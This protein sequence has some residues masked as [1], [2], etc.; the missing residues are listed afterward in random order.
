MTELT[1]APHGQSGAPKPTF[2]Q[3][4]AAC[5]RF[6]WVHLYPTGNLVFRSQQHRDLVRTFF[7]GA[8]E[9]LIALNDKQTGI[10]LIE[11]YAKM[12]DPNWWPDERFSQAKS[13]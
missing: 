5:N 11:E 13:N 12:A 2:D 6:L 4:V 8:F 7:A 3:L 1:R 9:M 10:S